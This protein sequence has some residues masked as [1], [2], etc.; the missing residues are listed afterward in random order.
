MSLELAIVRE[1]DPRR[2]RLHLIRAGKK[3]P[4]WDR[5][6]EMR[7]YG[8]SPRWALYYAKKDPVPTI[9]LVDTSNGWEAT[10][11]HGR[12]T[13]E[14]KIGFDEYVDFS[15]IG[16]FTDRWEEG[17]VKL[18]QHARHGYSYFIPE[19]KYEYHYRALRDMKVGRA[20][21]ARKAREYVQQD[22]KRAD[23]YQTIFI[24]TTARLNDVAL[25]AGHIG[26]IDDLDIKGEYVQDE[27]WEM[28]EE[29]CTQADEKLEKL[30]K[31][32]KGDS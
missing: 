32:M 22:V 27:V 15:W 11:V 1:K 29:A 23:D 6:L 7:A 10:I 2:R 19:C 30:T 8:Q 21:T 12:Y 28:I 3:P 16:E 14:V 17:A 24:A 25:G 31:S 9:N 26:G 18:E 5:Y 4:I 13:V 20:E